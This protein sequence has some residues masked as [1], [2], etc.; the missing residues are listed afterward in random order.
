M[1]DFTLSTYRHLLTTLQQAGYHFLTFEQYCVSQGEGTLP[2]TP[3]VILRHDVDM[4]PL[5]SLRIAQIEHQLGIRASYYFRIV[6][7][8]NQPDLIRAIAALGHEIGYHYEDMALV[9]G[10]TTQAIAHFRRSLAYFRR[11]YPVCTICMHGA[12]TS[13][14]DGRDLWKYYNYHDENI[15]GE[16]YFDMDFSSCLYLTDTGRCFDGYKVSVRDKIPRYQDQWTAAGLTYHSTFDVIHAISSHALHRNL[17]I[18]THPQRWTSSTVA[19]TQEL[20]L[21]SLKNIVKR[22]LIHLTHTGTLS[23]IVRVTR[24]KK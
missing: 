5:N 14:F 11:F 15:I 4:R 6:P 8:S 12:P 3:Y 23:Q 2:D 13:R 22:I 21:Q 20:L 1:R 17:M 18:T 7:R 19:W 9:H 10:D 24:D 16:P